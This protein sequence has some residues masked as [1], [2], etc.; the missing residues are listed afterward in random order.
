MLACSMRVCVCEAVSH[1][2]CCSVKVGVEWAF[3]GVSVF[4]WPTKV[5]RVVRS[6]S[7]LSIRAGLNN[8]R[9]GC[10][11]SQISVCFIE[12]SHTHTYTQSARHT[13]LMQRKLKWHCE[14]RHQSV[15]EN[16]RGNEIQDYVADC[17]CVCVATL[18]ET[19]SHSSQ[20]PVHQVNKTYNLGTWL[21]TSLTLSNWNV[22]ATRE[23]MN[24]CVLGAT[25]TLR[26]RDVR[27]KSMN[28]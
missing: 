10:V 26:M 19:H 15:S 9:P 20:L 17:V 27:C 3:K 7:T 4:E 18:N 16:A 22:F 28:P 1:Q 25:P 14:A 23:F 6:S 5:N 8:L 21:T 13:Y 12:S 2:V 11:S 24:L